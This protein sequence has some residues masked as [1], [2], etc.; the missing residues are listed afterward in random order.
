M[1]D[2][3]TLPTYPTPPFILSPLPNPSKP[4][5]LGLAGCPALSGETMI[6]S[7]A[8]SCVQITMCK[9]SKHHCNIIMYSS[10]PV[11]DFLQFLKEIMLI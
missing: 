5:N 8:V 2:D 6:S 10:H 9:R 4:Q 7:R 3:V 1:I 11:L